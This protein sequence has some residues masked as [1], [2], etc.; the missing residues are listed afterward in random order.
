M[1]WWLLALAIAGGIY[2]GPFVAASIR[3]SFF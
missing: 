2:F 3:W 1:K